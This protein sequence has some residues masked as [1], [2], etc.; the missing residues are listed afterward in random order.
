MQYE[1][2][3]WYVKV[4]LL[5][6]QVP[7]TGTLCPLLVPANHCMAMNKDDIKGN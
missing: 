1:F 2:C 6:S 4:H 3:T 5:I 7:R